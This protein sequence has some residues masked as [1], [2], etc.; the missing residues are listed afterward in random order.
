MAVGGVPE[1]SGPAMTTAAAKRVANR[2]HQR[3]WRQRQKRCAASYRCEADDRVIEML[4]RRGYVGSA[5]VEDAAEVSRAI[6][7]FMADHA[8]QDDL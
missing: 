2:E 8:Q 3:A 4:V 1:L 5:E 6:T 7:T